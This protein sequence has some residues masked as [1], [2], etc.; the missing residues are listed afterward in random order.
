MRSGPPKT[1]RHSYMRLAVWSG[2]SPSVAVR[3]VDGFFFPSVISTLSRSGCAPNGIVKDPGD[4]PP[5]EQSRDDA[6]LGVA[7]RQQRLQDERSGRRVRGGG[8]GAPP[9]PRALPELER[10]PERE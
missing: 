8:E 6:E 4:Q 9:I 2:R 5:I 10:Q 3:A 1:R 7:E